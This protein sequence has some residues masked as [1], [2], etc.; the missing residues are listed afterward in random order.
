MAKDGY[1]ERLNSAAKK[2]DT[3]P[4]KIDQI[5]KRVQLYLNPKPGLL[6]IARLLEDLDTI[7]KGEREMAKWLSDRMPQYQFHENP[8]PEKEQTV[9][10]KKKTRGDNSDDLHDPYW[11]ELADAIGKGVSTADARQFYFVLKIYLTIAK[12]TGKKTILRAVKQSPKKNGQVQIED[13]ERELRKIH[14]G[15]KNDPDTI[16]IITVPMGGKTSK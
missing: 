11:A 1:I 15:Y 2:F 16:H 5:C 13:V 14:Y 3:S 6:T 8:K 7:D 4:F 10:R 9:G 12:H